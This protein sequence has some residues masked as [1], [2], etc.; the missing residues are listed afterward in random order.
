VKLALH[1]SRNSVAIFCIDLLHEQAGSSDCAGG[2]RMILI[3]CAGILTRDVEPI[4]EA[5]LFPFSSEI[6]FST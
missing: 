4:S 1:R 6:A 3:T 2:V 5:Q